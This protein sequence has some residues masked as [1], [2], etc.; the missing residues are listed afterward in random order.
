LRFSKAG[1]C[2]RLAV[3]VERSKS[4]S[5]LGGKVEE[6]NE[7]VVGWVTRLVAR[8]ESGRQERTSCQAGGVQRKERASELVGKHQRRFRRCLLLLEICLILCHN[9]NALSSVPTCFIS[10]TPPRAVPTAF[11]GHLNACRYSGSP[12]ST[13]LTA[14]LHFLQMLILC[15]LPFFTAGW[16]VAAPDNMAYDG[17]ASLEISPPYHALGIAPISGSGTVR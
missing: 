9:L 1:R 16:G 6:N 12:L 10:G 2:P 17:V 13:S 4:C 15:D 11:S 14:S 3:A 5:C 7:Q 8:S